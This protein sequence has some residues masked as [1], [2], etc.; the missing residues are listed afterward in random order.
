DLNVVLP[1]PE[2]MKN[3]TV[4]ASVLES[5]SEE[6]EGVDAP[7]AKAEAHKAL[8]R[9][10]IL[11]KAV[12]F[13]QIYKRFGGS[14]NDE[15]QTKLLED[16]VALEEFED[17]QTN[18]WESLNRKQK[19]YRSIR[20]SEVQ[21]KFATDLE[22]IRSKLAAMGFIYQAASERCKDREDED[23]YACL[24]ANVTSGLK[25]AVQQK[26]DAEDMLVHDSRGRMSKLVSKASPIFKA[27]KKALQ[28]SDAQLKKEGIKWS[29]LKKSCKKETE[30]TTD[31]FFK[32]IRTQMRVTK[33][34]LMKCEEDESKGYC[35]EGTA[36][37]S[38]REIDLQEGTKW[39]A[40][41][42]FG[43]W[44]GGTLLYG[45]VGAIAMGVVGGPAGMI[46]GFSLGVG[47]AQMTIPSSSIG[48]AMF[49]WN[50]IGPKECAC[51]P[52]ECNK[53]ESGRCVMSSAAKAPSKNPFG[54]ALPYLSMKCGKIKGE[55]SLQ[56]CE[57]S[58]FKTEP[59]PNKMFGKVG[60]FGD[61]V[62]NCLA[63]EP[64]PGK[65]LAIQTTLPD[66]QENTAITRKAVF[67]SLGIQP[68]ADPK[69]DPKA[70]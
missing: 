68:K 52:R 28:E 54:R 33:S 17:A 25:D 23:T 60:E 56:A 8:I 38:G 51:F 18:H 41:G 59:L 2:I 19:I 7:N 61:G 39:F 30:E 37:Q 11:E 9:E 67:E 22:Q 66:G 34:S 55:C 50:A 44:G 40:I 36:P 4:G 29:K 64:R 15:L 65:A 10:C 24:M 49:A 13:G 47:L 70:K 63:T 12:G 16:V 27:A 21:K 46:A 26:L 14:W 57:P 53:V 31:Q 32:F 48:S 1:H 5:R 6:E 45:L 42:Y 3:V 69:E 35:P 58:D 62:Y 43:S 20:K